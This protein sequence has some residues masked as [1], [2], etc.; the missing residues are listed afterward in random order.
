MSMMDYV[1]VGEIIHWSR[2]SLL[3]P[4]DKTTTWLRCDGRRITFDEYPDMRY[5]CGDDSYDGLNLPARSE[6]VINAGRKVTVPWNDYGLRVHAVRARN[7]SI[8]L[9]SGAS[10]STTP[11]HQQFWGPPPN[12]SIPTPQPHPVY[13]QTEEN[14][15][16]LTE[17]IKKLNAKAE[18]DAKSLE[19]KYAEAL[20]KKDRKDEQRRNALSRIFGNKRRPHDFED[21]IFKPNGPV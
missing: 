16:R 5:L 13:S 7:M 10:M 4:D 15:R 3:P 20:E 1:K 17:T 8:P 19:L 14:L 21:K 6:Y 18:S 9:V 12:Y 11:M 2:T